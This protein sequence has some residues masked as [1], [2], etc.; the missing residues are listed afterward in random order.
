MLSF[1]SIHYSFVATQVLTS[2][3]SCH[4]KLDAPRYN[5]PFRRVMALDLTLGK[6]L[7]CGSTR[8]VTVEKP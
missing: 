7:Q 5:A 6:F 4:Q 2:A 1:V 8:I 3:L